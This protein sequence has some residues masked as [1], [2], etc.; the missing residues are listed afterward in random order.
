ML[1]KLKDLSSNFSPT[2][3]TKKKRIIAGSVEI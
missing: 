2:K 1:F 3:K